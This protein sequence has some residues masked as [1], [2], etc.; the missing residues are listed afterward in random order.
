M[1]YVVQESPESVVAPRVVPE[2]WKGT[3]RVG[4]EYEHARLRPGA[5]Y[6]YELLSMFFHATGDRRKAPVKGTATADASGVL[7]VPFEPDIRGEWVLT[8]DSTEGGQRNIPMKVAVYVLS[9]ELYRFRPYL[10]DLHSHST[11]SDGKQQA[12]YVPMRART[13]GFDFFALTDHWSYASS[14]EMKRQVGRMLG[15]R[16]LLLPGEEMHPERELLRE[17]ERP[18]GHF[19]HYH[20]VAVGHRASVRDAYLADPERSR[21][22]VR[23]IAEEIEQ[24]GVEDGLDLLPYAEGVWKLR[25]AKEL[26]ALTI[27][28]HPYWCHPVNLDAAAIEQSFADGEADAV[29][30]IST[31]DLLSYMPNR[32]VS[33]AA[34]KGPVP[35]VGVS[36]GH[37]WQESL[38]LRC[39][40]LVM[41]GELG[42]AAIFDA[43]RA[44][45]SVACR[46]TDPP[47]L[48]G[49]LE[50]VDFAMYYLNRILPRRRR[51]TSLQGSLALSA[52]RS[53]AFSQDVVDRLD[54]DLEALDRSMWA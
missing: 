13:Y 49:P 32:L 28:S 9:P 18:G 2:G 26:G 22:E 8:V 17:P 46:M 7:V 25:K 35:V 27:Y 43:I 53:G 33:L 45:R 16:M 21:L 6:S 54:A 3:L 44:G 42:E 11:S 50:L 38:P 5:S 23:R 34:R 47:Q 41:A 24:R 48:V 15:S 20:Y 37:D 36:D 14:V 30:A 10:G 40:T 4:G 29:E 19:H 31:A 52:L 39:C 51:V 1:P 12:A